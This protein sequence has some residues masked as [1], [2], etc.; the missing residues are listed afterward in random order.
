MVE[1]PTISFTHLPSNDKKYIVFSFPN[2]MHIFLNRL[3]F[4]F[5]VFQD[6]E[7]ESHFFKNLHNLFL[8]K[9]KFTNYLPI[10]MFDSLVHFVKWSIK[11]VHIYHRLELDIWLCWYNWCHFDCHSYISIN[12]P[13]CTDTWFII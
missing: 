1:S 7:G 3:I 10:K 12:D 11:T 4:L 13:H 2:Y 9:L 8:T 6:Y 5:L